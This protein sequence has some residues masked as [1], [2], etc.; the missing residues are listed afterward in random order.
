MKRFHSSLIFFLIAIMSCD[1]NVRKIVSKSIND[2][3]ELIQMADSCYQF[4][5]FKK[6]IELFNQIALF[7]STIGE[8]YYKRGYCKAQLFDYD[9]ASKDFVKACSLKY[10]MDE[11]LFNLGCIFAATGKDTLALKYFSKAYELNSNNLEAKRQM[12]H[13]K[14]SFGNV[15]L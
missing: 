1:N 15:E 6:S 3:T 5:D 8:V 7:D 12:D 14:R 11:S 2:K 9:G 10:R 4:K 13:F